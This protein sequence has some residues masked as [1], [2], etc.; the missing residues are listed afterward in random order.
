MGVAA[1]VLGPSAAILAI[2]IALM[3]QALFFGDGGITA[4]RA[5]C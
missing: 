3:I 2:S 4:F 1:I 5:N